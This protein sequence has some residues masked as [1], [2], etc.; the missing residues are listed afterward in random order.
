M[1]LGGVSLTIHP[2]L[3]SQIKLNYNIFEWDDGV[4]LDNSQ[5]LEDDG[6]VHGSQGC[7]GYEVVIVDDLKRKIL[8]LLMK[9]SNG[10]GKVK[11]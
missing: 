6:E 9:L 1:K 10:R 4:V 5:T 2:I 7:Y 11:F 8:K 3:V